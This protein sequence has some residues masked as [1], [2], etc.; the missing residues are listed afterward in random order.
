MTNIDLDMVLT[1][2]MFQNVLDI[3]F[4]DYKITFSGCDFKV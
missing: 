3:F 4:C 2:Q 1:G